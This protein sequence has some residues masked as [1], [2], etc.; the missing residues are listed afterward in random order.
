MW[1]KDFEVE[2]AIIRL[3]FRFPDRVVN[4]VLRFML[5][6]ST[7]LWISSSDSWNDDRCYGSVSSSKSEWSFPSWSYLYAMKTEL[8]LWVLRLRTDLCSPQFTNHCSALLYKSPCSLVRHRGFRR[9]STTSYLFWELCTRNLFHKTWGSS[10]DFMGLVGLMLICIN[11]A[12]VVV[13]Y[14]E[15]LKHK[16]ALKEFYI[17]TQEVPPVFSSPYL[18]RFVKSFIFNS[19]FFMCSLHVIFPIAH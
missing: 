18:T 2:V 16:F 7:R 11:Y 3:R 6:Q 14:K 5:A 4:C 12:Y 13:M 17:T 1:P 15:A 9:K 19:F 8:A 10:I